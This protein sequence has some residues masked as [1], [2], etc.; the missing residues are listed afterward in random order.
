MGCAKQK[1]PPQEFVLVGTVRV[2]KEVWENAKVKLEVC[3]HTKWYEDNKWEDKTD[4]W[5]R[6]RI[7]VHMNWFGEHY[8]VKSTARDKFGKFRVSELQ[9][10]I[11][12]YGT[13]KKEL[14][15][16]EQEEKEDKKRR[17]RRF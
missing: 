7:I 9:Y 4:K 16:G 14:W 10:G 6:F 1:F 8:R 11:V 5:G 13:D 2:E 12:R 3:R 15:I 17:R